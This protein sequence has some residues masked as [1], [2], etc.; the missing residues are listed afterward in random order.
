MKE[1]TQIWYLGGWICKVITGFQNA[2]W[3]FIKQNKKRTWGKI[4][5]NIW[6]WGGKGD[7]GMDG[8]WEREN[9]QTSVAASILV[10]F[11]LNVL[12][13]FAWIHCLPLSVSFL[14]SPSSLSP[15]LSLPLPLVLT[16]PLVSLSSPFS[17]SLISRADFT[18]ALS[19]SSPSPSPS[20]F[21]SP[22]HPLHLSSLSLDIGSVLPAHLTPTDAAHWCGVSLVMLCN[23]HHRHTVGHGRVVVGWGSRESELDGVERLRMRHMNAERG[24]SDR[25]CCS[26]LIDPLSYPVS[27]SRQSHLNLHELMADS[28]PFTLKFSTGA[29]MH[30]NVA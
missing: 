9:E 25:A 15:S 3:F 22:F 24:E 10:I 11:S 27:W 18:S 8:V 19:P 16:P 23:G 26:L 20:L 17:P 28:D 7:A 21:I 2:C 29:W 6:M 30:F 5:R 12:A 4:W 13:P 1:N 14:L